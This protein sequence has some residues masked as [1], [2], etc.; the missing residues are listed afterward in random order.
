MSEAL[1]R[2]AAIVDPCAASFSG[3]HQGVAFLF[4]ET[5]RENCNAAKFEIR[6]D[7]AGKFRFRLEAA[8]GEINADSQGYDTKAGGGPPSNSSSHK[9]DEDYRLRALT[10]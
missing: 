6:K 9:D 2:A 4:E 1:E 10:G 5:N 3:S 8:N 7:K